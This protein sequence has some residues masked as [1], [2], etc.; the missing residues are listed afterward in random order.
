MKNKLFNKTFVFTL[1][2][3]ASILISEI[4][5]SY[6]NGNPLITYIYVNKAEYSL[7]NS[8]YYGFLVNMLK[9]GRNKIRIDVKKGNLLIDEKKLVFSYQNNIEFTEQDYQSVNNLNFSDLEMGE[10]GEWSKAFYILGL[11]NYQPENYLSTIELWNTSIKLNPQWSYFHVELANLF[12]KQNDRNQAE[13]QIE[14][15]LSFY[16][17]RKDCNDYK[18]DNLIPN[19][20]ENIG[21][22]QKKIMDI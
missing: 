5:Y 12:L 11:V 6:Y 18:K 7:K 8:D 19:K 15:C 21:F 16:Y 20:P 13:N 4:I 14:K 1:L 3:T 2:F 9:A 17:P 10:S 22:L